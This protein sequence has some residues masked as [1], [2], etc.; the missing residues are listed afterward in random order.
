MLIVS[1]KNVP[2]GEQHAH[3][4][5]L[6]RVCLQRR[7]ADSSGVQLA[8]GEHGKPYLPEHPELHFNLSHTVGA[9]ACLVS[10]AECGVDIERVRTMR[11][12]VLR[13][14]YSPAEQQLVL[15]APEPERDM[16]FTRLWTLK[17]AYVKALGTG[18]AY[19][20]ATADFSGF[21]LSGAY[22]QVDMYS[23]RFRQYLIRGE[24]LLSV[25]EM[26]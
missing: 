13:R 16:L 7:L 25:C 24:L 11:E 15:S 1:L 4:H 19:P 20:L 5:S 8:Y 10:Q 14:A 18:I 2:K 23:C 9:A 12:N 3:A 17:E 6:L 21:T 22:S 26:I